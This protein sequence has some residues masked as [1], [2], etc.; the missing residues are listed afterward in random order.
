MATK[1]KPK[2]KEKSEA[3]ELLE[4]GKA[5][6]AN[7]FGAVQGI[8]AKSA[9]IVVVKAA[10]DYL[11]GKNTPASVE[12]I[13]MFSKLEEGRRY[14]IDAAKRRA[15]ELE[16]AGDDAHVELMAQFFGVPEVEEHCAK[17]LERMKSEEQGWKGNVFGPEGTAGPAVKP[18]DAQAIHREVERFTSAAGE[19]N[20]E[21]VADVARTTDNLTVALHAIDWLVGR[22]VA[23]PP[24]EEIA[25][26]I[27][28]YAPERAPPSLNEQVSRA[29]RLVALN[30]EL[31]E[32]RWQVGNLVRGRINA[33]E[34]PDEKA[35][36]EKFV[37]VLASEEETEVDKEKFDSDRERF[38]VALDTVWRSFDDSLV[39]LE[40]E[41]AWHQDPEIKA[42]LSTLME[43]VERAAD[44]LRADRETADD[45]FGR[46]NRNAWKIAEANTVSVLD[47]RKYLLREMLTIT[48][49]AD[50]ETRRLRQIRSAINR[51]EMRIAEQNSLLDAGT[52][53]SLAKDEAELASLQDRLGQLEG[54]R[55]EIESK[56][57][58]VLRLEVGVAGIG[59]ADAELAMVGKKL[60]GFNE[61]RGIDVEELTAQ[62]K[63]VEDEDGMRIFKNVPDGTIVETVLWVSERI[64]KPAETFERMEK[65]AKEGLEA[66]LNSGRTEA[67][68]DAMA[69]MLG[70]KLAIKSRELLLARKRAAEGRRDELEGL[71]EGGAAL[72]ANLAE[73]EGA[74]AAVKS[75]FD[76][77]ELRAV[78][79]R[80]LALKQDIEKKKKVSSAEAV[81]SMREDIART[82]TEIAA[83]ENSAHALEAEVSRNRVMP[84]AEF[85]AMALRDTE[86]EL[87][88]HAI[89]SGASVI[90][91]SAW[92]SAD[93]AQVGNYMVRLLNEDVEKQFGGGY[94]PLIELMQNAIDARPAGHKGEYAVDMAADKD[95]VSVQDMGKAMTLR[96]IITEL[97]VPYS[98]GTE[99]TGYEKYGRFGI[100][101]LSNLQYCLHSRNASITVRTCTG[102]EA[103]EIKFWSKSESI[104]DLMVEVRRL[105]PSGVA[106]G[107]KVTV[108][109]ITPDAAALE[110]YVRDYCGFIDWDACD[111]RFNK[112]TINNRYSY[113][114]YEF[115][116]R[117]VDFG[118]GLEG[119]VRVAVLKDAGSLFNKGNIRFYQGFFVNRW[120]AGS[121]GTDI[122]IDV[123]KAVDLAEQRD[124]FVRNDK[125]YKA[126]DAALDMMLEF[127]DS[128]KGDAKLRDALRASVGEF[129]DDAWSSSD[130]NERA[131]K[132]AAHLFEE[133]SFIVNIAGGGGYRRNLLDFAGA[134]FAR[135]KVY[136]TNNSS[137]YRAWSAV[138]ANE[139]A[140]FGKIAPVAEA[141]ASLEKV[142]ES[143]RW[144]ALGHHGEIE[145]VLLGL[146][147]EQT[148]RGGIALV[149]GNEDSANPFLLKF[150]RGNNVLY[151]NVAHRLF[152]DTGF[153]ARHSLLFNC[154]LAVSSYDGLAAENYILF[155]QK[156]EKPAP[157]PAGRDA[158]AESAGA[159]EKE[160]L[161]G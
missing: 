52:T 58:A 9:H 47:L 150:E 26:K 3:A 34:H 148:P 123:P 43:S 22:L 72:R 103:W 159:A 92:A 143:P 38:T 31:P 86:S 75:G 74:L 124:G 65:K 153:A 95:S 104:A 63:T 113:R 28:L 33:S 1:E 134:K 101:F 83:L 60:A 81:K 133:G 88:E 82:K 136:G 97:V 147:Q 17:A 51:G 36:L 116:E 161:G 29:L 48:T 59:D 77:K 90:D 107:T 138:I 15:D 25:G 87:L 44:E 121:E 154:L 79:K 99:K 24:P 71:L 149:E 35:V 21:A 53:A 39:K 7:D 137:I 151:V 109:G 68:S 152:K 56:E 16:A 106:K 30:A 4:L 67:L 49:D 19:L 114:G 6:N 8:G 66:A 156:P 57:N 73:S 96:E 105:D 94:R 27:V 69:Q 80:A 129:L 62:M 91:A 32:A 100:G 89:E 61:G 157:G 117:K 135:E 115:L 140:L 102:M 50:P 131:K 46:G 11:L 155:T 98:S 85:I 126:M 142:K 41:I 160:L 130:R 108:H 14:C 141:A 2:Q 119:K 23:N 84:L 13:Y 118:N 122:L 10:V 54:R 12:G 76:E 40:E 139:D 70:V 18:F 145:E 127:A 64:G 128:N 158:T 144:K 78:G 110:K 42:R 93:L 20:L 111:L 5:I 45:F 120:W 146:P 125:Y 37:E 112:A 55:R 132:A